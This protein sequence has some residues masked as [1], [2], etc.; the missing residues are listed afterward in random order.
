MRP[1]TSRSES[2]PLPPVIV[3]TQT[4]AVGS[5]FWGKTETRKN[6][7]RERSEWIEITVEPIVDQDLFE[8]AQQRNPSVDDV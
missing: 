1:R 3:I 8:A 4:A 2:R 7:P 6:R 5:F